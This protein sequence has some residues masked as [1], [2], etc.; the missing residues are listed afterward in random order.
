MRPSS[1]IGGWGSR[2]SEVNLAIAKANFHTL[3]I[4]TFIATKNVIIN[5]IIDE[6]QNSQIP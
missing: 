3:L 6:W 4:I 2:F 5:I 1:D